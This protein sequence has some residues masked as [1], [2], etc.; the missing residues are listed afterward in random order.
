VVRLVLALALV[1]ACSDSES[2]APETVIAR[3]VDE[4]RPNDRLK[5][6][7]VRGT[8][9]GTI[10]DFMLHGER[11]VKFKLD[12]GNARVTIVHKGVVPDLFRDGVE[13]KVLGRWVPN[14]EVRDAL[15]AEGFQDVL[16]EASDVFLSREIVVVAP[17]F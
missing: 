15:V 8:V 11:H 12:H 4:L 3:T 16:V 2:R 1:L 14:D 10:N 13:V 7:Q 17:D 6:V 5:L 9:G